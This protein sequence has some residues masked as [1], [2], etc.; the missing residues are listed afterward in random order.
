V[1]YSFNSNYVHRSTATQFSI[2]LM[3]I[4]QYATNS[5]TMLKYNMTNMIMTD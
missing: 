2:L 4:L 5:A 3:L 1:N